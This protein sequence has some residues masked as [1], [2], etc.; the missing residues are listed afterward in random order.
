MPGEEFNRGKFILFCW[1][2][3]CIFKNTK[4]IFKR[5]SLQNLYNNITYLYPDA[6]IW[7]IGMLRCCVVQQ[8]LT[9]NKAILS[10]APLHHLL[11]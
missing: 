10:V 2:G 1:N 7:V 6:N 5:D 11:A 9:I 3:M 4:I 8:F